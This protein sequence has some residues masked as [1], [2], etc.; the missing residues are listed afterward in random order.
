MANYIYKDGELMHYGVP[1]MRWGVRKSASTSGQSPSRKKQ[2]VASYSAEA[3]KMSDREL[4]QKI[5]RMTLENRYLDMTRKSRFGQSFDTVRDT[6]NAGSN[7]SKTASNIMKM[8]GKNSN[9]VAGK[10]FDVAS[11]SAS[12][13]KKVDTIGSEKRNVKKNRPVLDKMS[14]AELR[15]RVNRMDLERQYSTLKTG[16]V[17]RGKVK[18]TDVLSVAGDVL[19][20]GASATAIYLA[21]RKAKNG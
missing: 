13:V 17:K 11:K 16:S 7:A 6:A 19:A 8:K 21:I 12:V 10:V 18:A 4:R 1:G 9:N 2:K 5:D 15:D 3:K 20:I 14:D